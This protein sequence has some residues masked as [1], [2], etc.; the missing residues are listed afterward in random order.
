MER[1][2]KFYA[3]SGS[4]QKFYQEYMME[5]Q[6]AEDA[7][8]TREHIKFWKGYYDYDAD[9]NQNFLVISGERVPVN[10]FIG[11]DP[12]TD[13]D[14][15]EAD[16]S[17]IMCI[18]ID[19]DNNLYALEYERHRSIPTIGGK[20]VHGNLLNKKGVVDYILEMHQKYH[21]ISTTVEDVA[22]NRSIFQALNEER[23]R[24]N[25]FDVAV[26]PEKPGGRNKINRVY[27][28][29]SGRFSAGTV[30]VRQNMFDLINE[31]VTFGPR[32]AHDDTIETLFYANLH[33]FPPNFVQN[34]DKTWFKPK[35][36][37]KNWIVA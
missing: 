33:A 21:C 7:L 23:R 30:F 29:L 10:T 34:D 27:S 22:M 26:V 14:T 5:V 19:V 4:P 35:K 16:F 1:K 8:F 3:D 11:C 28:G 17:V 25:K 24:L 31:I 15:K 32:M 12:A 36:K 9:E 18:A 13:I 20:D 6:S 37:A 2:K